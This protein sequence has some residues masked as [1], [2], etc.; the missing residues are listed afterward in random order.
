MTDI[1]AV[2]TE[3]KTKMVPLLPWEPYLL[4]FKLKK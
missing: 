2:V 1:G 3:P 4:N